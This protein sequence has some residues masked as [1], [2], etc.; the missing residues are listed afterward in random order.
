MRDS[1]ARA[2]DRFPGQARHNYNQ[3]APVY[4]LLEHPFARRH[5]HVAI[6]V[7]D[8]RPGECVLEPGCGTGNNLVSIAHRVGPS[9]TVVGL[10]IAE[11]M[12]AVASEKAEDEGVSAWTTVS[13][14]DAQD[15]PCAEDSCDAVLLSFTIDLFP[16]DRIPRLLGECRRVLRPGG[17]IV[18]VSLSRRTVNPAVKAYE[19]LH[20]RFPCRI[21]CRPIRTS[22][23]LAEAGFDLADTRK[24]NLFGIPVDVVK[25]LH[26][27]RPR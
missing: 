24:L 16:R 27:K 4:D 12:V 10:D 15:L 23:H 9:G 19:W 5:K 7:L 17:R 13:V 25:A 22:E 6:H 2:V 11:R 18:V 26:P 21:D 14:C 20:D 1:D 3:L 8:P